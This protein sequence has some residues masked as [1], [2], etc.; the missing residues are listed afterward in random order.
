MFHSHLTFEAGNCSASRGRQHVALQA[1][2]NS[3]STSRVWHDARIFRNKG[4]APCL[5]AA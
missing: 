4:L 5:R 3:S 2:S 1:P